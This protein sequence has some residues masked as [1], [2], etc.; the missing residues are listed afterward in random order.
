M[1]VRGPNTRGAGKHLTA[2]IYLTNSQ[3]VSESVN[4]CSVRK[5]NVMNQG[6]YLKHNRRIC[7]SATQMVIE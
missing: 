3:R 4:Q 5:Q 7:E 6:V 1:S 2:Y